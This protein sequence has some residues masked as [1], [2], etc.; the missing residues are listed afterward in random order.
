MLYAQ[1]LKYL[2]SADALFPSK[3]WMGHND[4]W[5]ICIKS[6]NKKII[7]PYFELLRTL[8]YN[9]SPR[10]THFIFSQSPISSLCS[11]LAFPDKNNLL[12][13]RCCIAATKCTSSEA[14][15]LGCLLFDP[16]L[17]HAF[18]IAQAYW[19]A[20]VS[21]NNVGLSDK[22][23]TIAAGDFGNSSFN[24]SGYNFSYNNKEYFW[25]NNLESVHYDY[26]FTRLLFYPLEDKTVNKS[27]AKDINLPECPNIL[28]FTPTY[29][30][31]SR[32]EV[33]CCLPES[34]LRTIGYRTRTSLLT[35]REQERIA[36]SKAGL[37]PLIVRRQPWG[38]SSST[39]SNSYFP[40]E[41][42]LKK[43]I[44]HLNIFTNIHPPIEDEFRNLIL[45][46]KSRN[47]RTR[48]LTLNN[49]KQVFGKGLSVFPVNKYPPLPVIIYQ[50]Q[51]RHFPLIEV[52][53]PNAFLYVVQPFPETHP[54]LVLLCIK[55]SLTRP[56][57]SE[58]NTLLSNITPANGDRDLKPLYN[59]IHHKNESAISSNTALLAMPVLGSAVTVKF[60]IGFANDI[61]DKFRK[62]LQFVLAV[63]LKYPQGITPEQQKK[64]IALS[65]AICK[66]PGP[67]WRARISLL[68][69]DGFPQSQN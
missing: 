1:Q 30:L 20:A 68:A 3:F 23:D 38:T 64:I 51:I 39:L 56:S 59:K 35:T 42:I 34:G 54:A 8:F 7:I 9:T 44:H 11:P 29:N 27:V 46:F 61:L 67:I 12:T 28:Q 13:A 41:G 31:L 25:V 15:L 18:N 6:G 21:G 65:R 10:L 50:G 4:T 52:T 63:S 53:L 57:T 14:R 5:V 40:S 49:P 62:R 32:S 16:Q 60:C 17:I 36:I 55:Q 43:A 33:Q 22:T 37:L 2:F 58:W 19:R 47:Y 45:E 26:K 69:Y 66:T 24:A 48:R